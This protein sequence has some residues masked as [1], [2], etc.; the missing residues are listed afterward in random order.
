VLDG[1]ATEAVEAIEHALSACNDGNRSLEPWIRHALAQAWLAAGDPARAR[2]IAEEALTDCLEI[3]AR[4]VAIEAAVTLSAALRAE[5]GLAAAGRVEEL[6]ATADRLIV[7]TGARNL[8]AF[9]LVERAALAELRGAIG[10]QR[11]HL[12]RARAAFAQMGATG[13]ARE[14]GSALERIATSDP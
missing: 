11:A 12:A 1:R 13:R 7:E 10:E 5:A 2:V 9:V 14:V 6:L 3:G 4:L 8:A